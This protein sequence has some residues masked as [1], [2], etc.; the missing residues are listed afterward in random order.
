MIRTSLLLLVG[1]LVCSSPRAQP[2]SHTSSAWT[3][4]NLDTTINS[5]YDERFPTI[6]ADRRSLYFASDRPGGLGEADPGDMQAL[7]IYVAQ[8]SSASEPWGPPRRLEA[9]INSAYSDH[10]V[11]ISQDG[12][13]MYFSSDRLGGC[14]MLDI[15]LSYREDPTDDF[16]WEKPVN[17]GCTVNSSSH[18][19]CPIY[20]VDEETGATMLYLVSN[21][22]GGKIEDF[23]I[24]VSQRDAAKNVFTSP[25][26]IEDVNSAAFDG[27]LEPIEGLI[28]STRKGGHGQADLWLTS[29]DPKTEQWSTPVNL[30]PAINTK[31][32]EEMPTTTPDGTRLYFPSNRP[33]G[34][35]GFDLYVATRGE[36]MKER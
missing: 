36:P 6:S 11:T 12:H 15:Y 2:Q 28:W 13:W 5:P 18:E 27:H 16:G 25:V 17:L 19:A 4:T 1:L 9:P 34:A 26:P 7:D 29:Q 20:H 33:G 22:R 32:S 23:D 14:G 21:K 8:R 35:G 3:V 30:G 31:N 24:Y 10:S